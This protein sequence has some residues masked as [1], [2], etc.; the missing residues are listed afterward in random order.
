MTEGCGNGPFAL[1]T[2]HQRLALRFDLS[3]RTPAVDA[4]AAFLAACVAW[5]GL[6]AGHARTLARNGFTAAFL[7][8][9][10]RRRH[11]DA[12]DA[13]IEGFR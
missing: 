9:A 1:I 12:V 6:D 4:D 2:V 7:P 3:P 13:F 10:E 5:L 8:E 11:L